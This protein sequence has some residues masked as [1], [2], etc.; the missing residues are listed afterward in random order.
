MAELPTGLGDL[1][2]E[3]RAALQARQQQE[4]S[5][6]EQRLSAGVQGIS[7]M[8]SSRAMECMTLAA[9]GKVAFTVLLYLKFGKDEGKNA[10]TARAYTHGHTQTAYMNLTSSC[11]KNDDGLG[12]A[13]LQRVDGQKP[14]KS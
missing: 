3:Q 9:L 4:M 12:S 1:S 14:N 10:G 5:T 2:P 6:N 11:K 7:A 13:E 8:R